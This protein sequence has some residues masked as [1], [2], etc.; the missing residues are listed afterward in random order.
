MSDMDDCIASSNFFGDKSTLPAK[1]AAPQKDKRFG[2]NMDTSNVDTAN[3]DNPNMNAT[4]IGTIKRPSVVTIAAVL[5]I[6]L[7]LFVAGLGIANQFGLFGR[8]FG[9]SQFVPGQF[10]NRNFTPPSGSQSNGFPQNGFPQNGLPN[11]QNNR[12]TNPNFTFNRGAGT[13]IAR[14]LQIISPVMIV[15][16]IIVLV[17]SVIAAIGLFKTK[18]WAA[19][20]AIV[21]SALVILLTIPGMIR[22]FS[23][24]T[25]VEN[26]VRILMAVAVIV[27]LLL[28]AS[29]KSYATSKVEKEEEVERIVR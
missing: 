13:G 26:L 2:G 7:S 25:L 15:L 24:V 5:L 29:R 8:G 28:P 16:D 4:H 1:S 10:R 22:I 9:N 6:I 19:I 21:L 14:I 20:M 12:G 23:P 11:D 18:L 3:N 27:L 17:L